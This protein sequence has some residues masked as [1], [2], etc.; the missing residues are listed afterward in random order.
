VPPTSGLLEALAVVAA[1]GAAVATAWLWDGARLRAVRRAAGLLL[2]A[3]TALAAVAVGINRE[4][5]LYPGWGD[6]L[7]QRTDVR[8]T[9]PPRPA[10]VRRGRSEVVAWTFAGR[11]SRIR[12][13]AYVY[14]PA[15]YLSRDARK[16]R[17]PVIEVLAGFPGGPRS[18]LD[19]LRLRKVIDREIRAGRMSPAV[20]VLPVQTRS[21][22]RDSE[23][24]DAVGGDRYDTYLSADL[25]EALGVSFR[26]RTDRDAWGVAGYSTG[27]FC[28]VN[29]AVRH[30]DQYAA[31]ASLSGYF[32]PLS[33]ASTGDLYRGDLAARHA[34]DPVWRFSHAPSPNV[35]LYLAAARDDAPAMRQ[36]NRLTAVAR[37]PTQV[38]TA[39]VS[40]GGHTFPAWGALAP[41]ALDWVSA[42]LATS[43]P[44][45]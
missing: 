25:R 8:T 36:I 2:C 39:L 21:P 41:A 34:N 38:T 1:V 42:H 9:P 12:H 13:P 28:A 32:S 18:W 5:R 19:R 6:V 15:A 43:A 16:V 3:S 37:P 31:A 14:L 11:Q 4:M 17:F 24:V 45:P 27:G 33:D 10:E 30:P 22:F 35:A 23:C 26:V 7:G 40:G 29:L 20:V 44:G